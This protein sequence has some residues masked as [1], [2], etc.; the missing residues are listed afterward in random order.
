[1]QQRSQLESLVFTE[2]VFEV[3]KSI[4]VCRDDSTPCARED[5]LAIAVAF[6]AM[7]VAFACSAVCAR[8]TSA[9][10]AD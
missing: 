1:M 4:C 2:S 6:V 5:S 8:D 7:F 10:R 3:M 9:V